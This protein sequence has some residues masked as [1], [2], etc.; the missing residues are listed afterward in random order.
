MQTIINLMNQMGWL[1]LLALV[2]FV[3]CAI[4]FIIRITYKR[5]LPKLEKTLFHWDSAFLKALSRPLKCLIWLI[6][7][8][9]C[10]EILG[11]HFNNGNFSSTLDSLRTSLSI[12]LMLWLA[13]RFIKNLE[14]EYNNPNKK[15]KKNYDKTTVRAA[16]QLSRIASLVLAVLIFL[17]TP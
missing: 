4:H 10:I 7:S 16:C 5:L 12:I 15:R 9:F 1:L 17:Q 3:T 6:S 14:G 13:L 8:T 2:I 11:R